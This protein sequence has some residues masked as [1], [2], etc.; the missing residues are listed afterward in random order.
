M[1]IYVLRYVANSLHG[2]FVR[3]GELDVPILYHVKNL[4][5]GR[6]F[7]QRLGRCVCVHVSLHCGIY[8][9]VLLSMCACVRGCSYRGA[10]RQEYLQHF[11]LLPAPREGLGAP[12][13]EARYYTPAIPGYVHSTQ[14]RVSVC[15]CRIV[16][17]ESV[18]NVMV[19]MAL[20]LLLC[21]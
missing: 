8:I 1:H 6:S 13:Q 12:G 19:D 5:N 11:D 2:L 3:G 20:A 4:R 14:R 10:A 21:C 9:F 17:V 18:C 16:L 7:C 15:M